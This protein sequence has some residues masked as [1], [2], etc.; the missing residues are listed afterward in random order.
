MAKTFSGLGATICD[1]AA[2]LP[3]SP[4]EGMIVYQKD[5]N[6]LK[7]HDGSSWITML[8]TDAPPA[9]QLVRPTS[10]TG[11][12]IN[13]NGSVDF[14]GASVLRLN[15]VFTSDFT[16]YK[17]IFNGVG[18]GAT[19]TNMRFR[20]SAGGTDYDNNYYNFMV[21]WDG[22]TFY[23]AANSNTTYCEWMYCA[24]LNARFDMDIFSPNVATQ[25]SMFWEHDAWGTTNNVK[26]TTKSWQ[27]AARSYDGFSITPTGQT[28]SGNIRVYGY[29]N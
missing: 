19:Y 17:V 14:S 28:I 27:Y 15:G 13:A 12:T 26:G 22:V 23:N 7:I 5:T 9:L 18:S 24:N 6:E 2:D 25:T 1:T 10:V 20:L 4:T 8:D 21:Y 16:N 11:G 3:S 29:R